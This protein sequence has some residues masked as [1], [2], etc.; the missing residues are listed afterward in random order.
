MTRRGTVTGLELA[1]RLEMHA[2]WLVPCGMIVALVVPFVAERRAAAGGAMAAG[3]ASVV[4]MLYY[5]AKFSSPEGGDDL[6]FGRAVREAFRIETGAVLSLLSS[7]MTI[8]RV[9]ELKRSDQ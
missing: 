2:L 4:G 5:Y 7:L 8:G 3:L 6:G 9:A 1:S